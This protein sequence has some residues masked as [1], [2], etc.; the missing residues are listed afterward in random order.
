MKKQKSRESK[1][2]I[3]IHMT[4][5]A[6]PD[7]ESLWLALDTPCLASTDA[8]KH[9]GSEKLHKMSLASSHKIGSPGKASCI[10]ITVLYLHLL[11]KHGGYKTDSRKYTT[12]QS[13][14]WTLLF[15]LLT[16]GL[17]GVATGR[18]QERERR[19]SSWDGLSQLRDGVLSLCFLSS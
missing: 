5:R 8:R 4:R 13:K 15:S 19:W 17:G 6:E 7:R 3:H 14:P 10:E 1:W 2:I 11:R 16:L 18:Q 12:V 9:P